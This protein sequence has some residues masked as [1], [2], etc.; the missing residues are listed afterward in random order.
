MP[1]FQ[2]LQEELAKPRG[3]AERFVWA[4]VA[5]VVPT[6]IRWALDSG[7]NGVPFVTYFPAVFLASLFLG[8]RYS[9]LVIGLSALA[10]RLLFMHGPAF[11]YKP[12]QFV[13]LG[14]FL[15]SC[16][17]LVLSSEALRQTVLKLKQRS[18]AEIERNIELQHRVGNVLTVAQALA[19]QTFKYTP[20][21]QFLTTYGARLQ[22]LQR[23]NKI[24]SKND[25]R[26]C[27]LQEI[28]DEAL[29]PFRL[30]P[31]ISATGPKLT[32]PEISCVPLILALH[33]LA[34]N[35]V[36]YGSLS[37][38][39]GRVGLSWQLEADKN[40]LAVL[41]WHETG[42]PPVSRPSRKGLGSRLL[43]SQAGLK[44]VTLTFEPEGLFCEIQIEGAELVS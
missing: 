1:F 7:A 19:S 39:S 36:K 41:R 43:S 26:S 18:E 6:L 17:L 11:E 35:A 10:A 2:S 24:L 9:L 29:V 13:I 33:E 21:D 5:V 23:A 38:E 25:F 42:G 34:T 37:N 4:V 32:L 12:V 30:G 28:V 31:N 15:L 44:S 3:A 16:A 20:A 14:F 27:E 40:S 22:A 8:W